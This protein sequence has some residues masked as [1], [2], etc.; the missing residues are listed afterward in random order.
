MKQLDE[1]SKIGWLTHTYGPIDPNIYFNHLGS[2]LQWSNKFN[3]VFIGID[4][5]RVADAR[6]ILVQKAIDM[7]CTHILIIDAD[8]ILPKHMLECLSNNEDALVVS[9]L[10]TKRKLPYSQVGFVRTDD[11][12]GYNPI[13]IPIDGRSYLVD[14]PAMGCTLIDVDIFDTISEPYFVDTLA[15]NSNGECYNKRSDTNFFEK[16][17]AANHKIIIDSRVL[18]GHMRDAEPV[19]PDCVPDVNELNKK[20]K[21][22]TSEDS[23]KHQLR[24]Y[25]KANE[26]AI[27]RGGSRGV[28]DLG[29]GNPVKLTSH[30]GGWADKIIGV[31]L[32]EKIT[33]IAEVASSCKVA[34]KCRWLG[35]DL[36][37]EFTIGDS[38][39]LVISA[40]VIEH[41][42]CPGSLLETAKNHMTNDS[43]FIISSPEKSTTRQ[44]NPLHKQE[45][46]LEELSAL[47]HDHGLT[48]IDREQYQ[49]EAGDVPYTNNICICKLNEKE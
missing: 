33:S 46:T 13:S 8:H 15:Q 21:I 7:N 17:R 16:V 10:V 43:I 48:I 36:N 47:I 18:V 6:N 14:V 3:I 35:Y 20:N 1:N 9:G 4:K 22:R 38:F 26:L 30:L 5:H 31:D 12:E 40:D 11:G 29:C 45:F 27:L 44:D 32:P 23:M 28:L 41:L 24:I 49:E 42:D 37:A 19:F 25:D 2:M 39:G 34:N